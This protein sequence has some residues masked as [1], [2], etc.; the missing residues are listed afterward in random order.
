MIV[1]PSTTKDVSELLVTQ[2]AKEKEHNRR[3]FLKIVSSIR[4]LSRQGMAFRGDRNDEDSNFLQLLQLKAEDDPDLLEWLKRKTSKYTSHEIQNDII[5]L[6][7]I[8]V[9]RNIT[10]SLQT[11]QFITLMMDETT[12]ISNK[13]QVTFTIRWVSEDLEVHEEFIGLYEVP[14]I[15]AATLATVAKDTFTRLN[16]SFSK[17]RGQCY[18]GASAMK[19]IRSGLVPRIQ[20][21]EPHTIYTHCYGHSINLAAN[22]ALKGSKLLKDALDMTREITKLIKYSPRREAIFQSLKE[23]SHFEIENDSSSG[24]RVLCPTRWTVCADSLGSI[25]DNY[26]TLQDTWEEAADIVHDTET[27]ARIRG[28]SSQMKTFNFLFGTVLCE[29]LLRHTDNLSKALQKKTISA[30][31][32]QGIAKM[33]IAT[34]CTL[35][36]EESFL[37]FWKKVEVVARSNTVDEPQLPRRR[38]L[39]TRYDDGL[40]SHEFHDSPMHYYRQLYYEAIDTMVSCLKD[41]FEQPGYQ[42]YSN[43]EQILIKACQGKELVEELD[44]IC[45]FYKEDLQKDLLRVQLQTLHVDFKSKFEERYGT[46]MSEASCITI[47]DIKEYFQ[48]LSSAQKDLL[49]QV[50]K[51]AKL[52]LVMPATNATSERSFSALRRVKSYLRNSMSQQRLNNLML[53]HVHKVLTDSI[54][55]VGVANE[56]VG[57]S[58]HRLQVFGKFK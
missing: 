21:L 18:D 52:V 30:A 13:E 24:I 58:E 33:V 50:C 45:N 54:D 14:A 3:M 57:E 26:T 11:S 6:M 12:D 31:E 46:S 29:V 5:K 15:D 39:P 19:G 8:S 2:L 37:L 40:A 23:Q 41:R 27:K 49:D 32:G 56:F 25:V 51:V 7:A 35:Q 22:D 36:T 17:L 53:L 34:L 48:S 55:V 47:F 9:L 42:T 16:L 10:T 43:L 20:E 28:V 1:L 38:R 4:F 44:F